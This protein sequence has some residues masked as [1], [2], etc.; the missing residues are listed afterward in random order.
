MGIKTWFLKPITTKTVLL[1]PPNMILTTKT[2]TKSLAIDHVYFLHQI[3]IHVMTR[4][5]W[6]LS[7]PAVWILTESLDGLNLLFPDSNKIEIGWEHDSGSA[8]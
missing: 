5:A 7:F 4:H 3:A 8:Q 1:T 6:L 2:K